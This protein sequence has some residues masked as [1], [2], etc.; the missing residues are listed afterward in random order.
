LQ[1]S[2]KEKKLFEMDGMHLA[3]IIFLCFPTG[4]TADEIIRSLGDN[5][6]FGSL[7]KLL[8]QAED[9]EVVPVWH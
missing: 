4:V 5:A 7:K 9:T 8:K 6:A 2:E 1:K 3:I